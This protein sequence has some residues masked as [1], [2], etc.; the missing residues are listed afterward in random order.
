MNNMKNWAKLIALT[1]AVLI[2]FGAVLGIAV[3]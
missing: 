3:F 2:P 1:L